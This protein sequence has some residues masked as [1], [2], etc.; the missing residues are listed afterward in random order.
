VPGL[1][2]ADFILVGGSGLE[3]VSGKAQVIANT[4]VWRQFAKQHGAFSN[5]QAL[6]MI[7]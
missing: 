4:E 7:N 2:S 5:G 3:K 1:G 6:S